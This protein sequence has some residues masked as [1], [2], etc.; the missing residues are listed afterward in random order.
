MPQHI[1]QAHKRYT[2]LPA[3][4]LDYCSNQTKRRASP[5]PAPAAGHSHHATLAAALHQRAGRATTATERAALVVEAHSINIDG[6]GTMPL[7]RVAWGLGAN[8]QHRVIKNGPP[9]AWNQHA[10]GGP[11]VR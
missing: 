11:F 4:Y 3:V 10:K 8:Q 6:S 2:V 5:R 9:P 1:L 7:R